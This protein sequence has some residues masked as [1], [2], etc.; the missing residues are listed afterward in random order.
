MSVRTSIALAGLLCLGGCV[1]HTDDRLRLFT[2][3]GV[4]QF[5]QAQYRDALESFELAL[6][7]NPNDAGL[8]F[9]VAECYDRLGA[10]AQAE[11]YYL[12]CL[13]RAPEHADGR[14]GLAALQYRVAKMPE[15]NRLIEEHLQQNPDSADALVLDAWRLRQEK[16]LP[17][18]QGRL[19]QALDREPHNRRALAELGYLYETM[20][21][22]ERAL[23][24]YERILQRE[25][26]REDIVVRQR[27]LKVAGTRRP[28]LD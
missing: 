19:Q 7:L 1:S 14:L 15:A 25:P 10:S 2:E 20:G 22:P 17:A 4:E 23:V 8:L 6:T 21:M 13:Q 12:Y 24:L 26:G 9:N 16:N 28:M 27:A 3:D 18:A 11:Q 5:R